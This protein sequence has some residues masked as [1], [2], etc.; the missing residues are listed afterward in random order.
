MPTLSGQ[1]IFTVS[2]ETYMWE[3]L[4]L[5]ARLWGD[6]SKLE[7]RVRAGLAC[8]ARLE[9]LDEGDAAIP[10]ESDVEAAAEEFRYA[11]DLVSAEEMEAWLER[12]GLTSEAWLDSVERTLLLRR[13]AGVLDTIVNAYDIEPQEIDAVIDCEAICGGLAADLAARLAARAAVYARVVAAGAGTDGV[14]AE[15]VE[16]V[17]ATAP[18]SLLEQGLPGVPP[19]ACRARLETLARLDVVWHRFAAAEATPEGVR[20]LISAHRLEWIR[21]SARVVTTADGDVANEIALCVRQDGSDLA[22]SAKE[23]GLQAVDA[24]WYLDDI[25]ASL[26]E[27]LVGARPGDL[28]GPLPHVG[29]FILISVVD[30]VLPTESDPEICER[31]ERALLARTVDGE[32]GRRVTWHAAL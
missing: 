5:A 31:A 21:V 18:P 27:R 14:S 1:R 6:W 8:G 16:A 26:R 11:R 7:D 30:K 2:G 32:I 10:D 29:G 4:V 22:V 9:D 17:L 12:R 23:A 20:S 13:W 28:L 15:A 3:D 19:A 25:D 24:R